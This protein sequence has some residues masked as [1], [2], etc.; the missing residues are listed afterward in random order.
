MTMM[1]IFEKRVLERL[2]RIERDEGIPPVDLVRQAVEV[3]SAATPEMRKS[4]GLSV[5]REMLR[6]IGNRAQ[7]GTQ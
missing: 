3:W 7:G 1:I 4:M 2:E 5:M 6:S